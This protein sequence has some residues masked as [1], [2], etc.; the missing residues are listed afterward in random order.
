[1]KQ[2]FE[3]SKAEKAPNI[4]PLRAGT[5]QG[6]AE[7]YLSFEG[8][9][10]IGIWKTVECVFTTGRKL[11]TEFGGFMFAPV[12]FKPVLDNDPVLLRLLLASC[13]LLPI[14]VEGREAVVS[15]SIKIVDCVDENSSRIKYLPDDVWIF[16]PDK[17]SPA[18]QICRIGQY[19]TAVSIIATDT[20]L[21]P[22]EDFYQWYHKQNYTGLRFKLLWQSDT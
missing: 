1:M 12:V 2:V 3:I 16:V 6:I 4:G 10:K 11:K 13:E 22:E 19:R 20:N 17:L 14:I 21:P 9:P 5:S 15:H 7:R 18:G 8:N